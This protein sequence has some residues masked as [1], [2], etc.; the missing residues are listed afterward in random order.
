MSMLFLA[1]SFT[2]FAQSSDIPNVDLTNTSV[3]IGILTPI[4][5]YFVTLGVK[6]I[7]PAISGM[8]TI[9][10]TLVIAGVFTWVTSY[11]EANQ[12]SWLGQLGMG[13]LAVVIDQVYYHLSGQASTDK[14]ILA[15][16][17]P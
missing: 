4:V 5:G 2:A 10:L 1:I 11:I 15:R 12:L 3:L 17:K 6:K 7:I 9:A 14:A 8:Y 16:H 13:L